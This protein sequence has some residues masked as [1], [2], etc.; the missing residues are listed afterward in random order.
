[1]SPVKNVQS[2]YLAS[3]YDTVKVLSTNVKKITLSDQLHAN[4]FDNTP[5]IL[6]CI[7]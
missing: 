4:H 7:V 6:R 2:K 5:Y 1:M 3:L